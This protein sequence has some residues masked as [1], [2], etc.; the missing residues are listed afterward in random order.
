MRS[1]Y[2]E[3]EVV[4]RMTVTSLKDTVSEANVK[5]TFAAGHWDF[6]VA[7]TRLITPVEVVAKVIAEIKHCGIERYKYALGD[8]ADLVLEVLDDLKDRMESFQTTYEEAL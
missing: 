5:E 8:R 3:H 6:D 1:L 7:D 4:V 2:Y